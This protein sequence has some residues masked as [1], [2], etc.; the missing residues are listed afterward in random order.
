MK[1]G[2]HFKYLYSCIYIFSSIKCPQYLRFFSFTDEKN[3]FFSPFPFLKTHFFTS[4]V[5][6][7]YKAVIHDYLQIHVYHDAV[8]RID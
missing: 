8:Q 5:I 2:F 6:S 1:M 7:T 3:W 4:L